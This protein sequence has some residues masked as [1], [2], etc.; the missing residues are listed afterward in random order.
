SLDS[1]GRSSLSFSV[2]PR[3]WASEGRA[4]FAKVRDLG[5]TRKNWHSALLKL[6]RDRTD[7]PFD[8]APAPTSSAQLP[9]VTTRRLDQPRLPDGGT[10]ARPGGGAVA[11][12]RGHQP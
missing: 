4:C 5:P 11:R 1:I 8:R 3:R 7:D 12:P 6:A 10:P 9:D 2:P